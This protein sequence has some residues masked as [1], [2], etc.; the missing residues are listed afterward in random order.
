MRVGISQHLRQDPCEGDVSS[1]IA[2]YDT[3]RKDKR[4]NFKANNPVQE[5]RVHNQ[6]C[7]W[8]MHYLL[9]QGAMFAYQER[10][11]MT[12]N[13]NA[14]V[15]L[16]LT[17]CLAGDP[18]PPVI[19]K[20]SGAKPTMADMISR[21]PRLGKYTISADTPSAPSYQSYS[22][23]GGLHT[24]IIQ[25]GKR[26]SGTWGHSLFQM[27]TSATYDAKPVH[28]PTSG[29]QTFGRTLRD[30]VCGGLLPDSTSVYPRPA[31]VGQGIRITQHP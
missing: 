16:I 1:F 17:R 10:C 15:P 7:L 26:R 18:D 30:S 11:S 21:M 13:P 23:L 5:P 20:S 3:F 25:Q 14:S 4:H 12:P 27:A 29:G 19:P 8:V 31:L 28:P 6:T 22:A 2:T 24:K 9:H